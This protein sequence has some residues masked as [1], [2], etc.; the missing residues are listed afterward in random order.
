LA[1]ETRILFISSNRHERFASTL[2]IRLVALP[3]LLTPFLP[4]VE[5]L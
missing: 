5:W 1:R 4:A 2:L 3:T